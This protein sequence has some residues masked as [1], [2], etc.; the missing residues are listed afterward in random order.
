LSGGAARMIEG[1]DSIIIAAAIVKILIRMPT[2]ESRAGHAVK[3]LTTK[4]I[5][6]ERRN[7]SAGKPASL[8]CGW[9]RGIE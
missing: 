1:A 9:Y 5:S 7:R 2:I 3:A 4:G 8:S 6:S